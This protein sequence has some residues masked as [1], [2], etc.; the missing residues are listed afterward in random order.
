MTGQRTESTLTTSTWALVAGLPVEIESYSITPLAQPVSPAFTRRTTVIHLHGGGEDG[1]GEDVTPT[2]PDQLAFQQAVLSLPLAGNW[3][4]A[5]FSAHVETLDP[6]PVAPPH[7]SLRSFRRWAFE[8]AALDLALRQAGRS[9]ADVLGKTPRP[10]TFVNSLRLPDPPTI[11][12]IR[13][14]LKLVPGLRFKLDPTSAWNDRLIAE[15]AATGAIDTLDL[16]GLYPPQAPIAQPAD[17]D[18]YRR[19]AHAFP[20][21][22]IEDPALTPATEEILRPHRDRITWDFPIRTI[23]DIEALPYPPRAL[24]VKPSRIGTLHGLLELYDHCA[25][26]GIEMYGGGMGE[27]GPG[28]T[29]IQLLASLF[30]PSAPNDVAPSVYNAPQPANGL[31]ASPLPTPRARTGFQ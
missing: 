16:K 6:F 2:E 25:R 8:G 31:P 19:V 24:N 5:S 7:L 12:P 14:R 21:C 22:W 11:E 15:L 4:L 23:A 26:C 3:T 27:L 18:L 17:P 9:L 20:E 29:Q 13:R 30:H 10:V 28:R 1:V